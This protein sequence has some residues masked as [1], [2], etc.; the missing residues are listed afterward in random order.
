[1]IT[2]SIIP[3]SR[4]AYNPQQVEF[5]DPAKVIDTRSSS[6]SDRADCLE[7]IRILRR[8]IALWEDFAHRTPGSRARAVATRQVRTCARTLRLEIRAASELSD[9]IND[10]WVESE[11]WVRGS[12]FRQMH[13]VR[14][15]NPG[16]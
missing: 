6:R 16:P 13:F 14:T 1:L 2:P 11:E 12:G 15:R 8:I 4:T 10:D 7:R 5:S 9:Q 3:D